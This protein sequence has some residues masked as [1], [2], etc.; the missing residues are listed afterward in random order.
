[1]NNRPQTHG[2]KLFRGALGLISSMGAFVCGISMIVVGKAPVHG[3]VGF[4]TPQ[5]D[6]RTFWGII[7]ICFTAGAITLVA[8]IRALIKSSDDDTA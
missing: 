1:M 6:P 5:N 8:S 7:A 2:Q 3:P 4:V